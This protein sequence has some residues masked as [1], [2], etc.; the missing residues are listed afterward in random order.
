[1]TSRPLRPRR[2]PVPRIA[3]MQLRGRAAPLATRV[4]WPAPCPSPGARPALMVLFPGGDADQA[5]AL[6]R[7]LCSYAGLVVLTLLGRPGASDAD[8]AALRDACT[9]LDWAADHAVELGA[10]PGRLI[11]AGWETGA[12]PAAAVALHARDQG[13]PPIARQVLI[14]PDLG[15]DLAGGPL[16][17]ASVAG[18]ASATVVGVRDGDGDGTGG[19][20]GERH[21]VGCYARRLRAAGVRVDELRYEGLP[22]AGLTWLPW[23]EAADGLVGDLARSLQHRLA[24]PPTAATRLDPHTDDTDD[25][26]DHESNEALR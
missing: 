8:A 3:D 17:A 22:S 26:T 24:L 4:Y 19:I 14:C 15:P 12:R 18:V 6:S 23:S 5:D 2:L 21:D 25:D 16:D 11:V 1:M 20:G 10:D 13:W 9:A 7:G